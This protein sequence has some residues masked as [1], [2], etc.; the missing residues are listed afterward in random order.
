MSEYPQRQPIPAG[1]SS[2]TFL[3]ERKVVTVVFADISGFTA[4]SETLDPETVRDMMN[5]CFDMLVPVIERYGGTIDKFIGDAVMALFGA[6]TAHEND[7][8]RALRAA[9]G[10]IEAVVQ[11]NHE[12]GTDLGVHIGI[13]TG[14]VVAGGI[15]SQGRQ[16]YSV[17][18]DAVNLAARLEDASE[19][20]EILVGPDTARAVMQLFEFDA[21]R[22]I[23]FKG[24]SQPVP[25]YRL[26]GQRASPGRLRGI[27]GLETPIVGR[28]RE[29]VLLRQSLEGLER[30]RGH[31]IYLVGDA[32]LGKSRLID[33]LR[34][35]YNPG[36]C[37]VDVQAI[38]YQ[39]A[40]PYSLFQ[41]LLRRMANLDE[42]DAPELSRTRIA[43]MLEELTAQG[44]VAFPARARSAIEAL[45]GVAVDT[46]G[47]L[48]GESLRRELVEAITAV[49]QAWTA[50]GPA[51]IA[52]DDLHWADALSVELL[53]QL[54]ALVSNNPLLIICAFRPERQSPIQQLRLAT[55][56]YAA[57]YVHEIELRPLSPSESNSL[58]D[59]LLTIADLPQRLRELILEKA[60]GNPFFVEE[61]VRELILQE[62]VTRSAD[63]LRWYAV[64][65]IERIALPES[66]QA[67]LTTRIDRLDEAARQL[68]Q[69]AAVIGRSFG[70]ATLARVVDAD[71]A[72]DQA[73]GAL[74][75]ADLIYLVARQPE[76]EYAF[77]H[78]LAQEA[79]YASIL[80]RRRRAY[81]RRVGDAL[82]AL[83]PERL[84]ELAHQL[85]HHFAEA[86]DELRAL[87]YEL[88]AGDAAF[89][90]YARDAAEDHYRHALSIVR[91]NPAAAG[92]GVAATTRLSG[93]FT[94][95]GRALELG[96]RW[97]EAMALYVELI[98][99]GRER[100]DAQLELAGFLACAVVRATPN[101][102]QSASDA[103]ADGQAALELAR[104]LGNGSA[105]AR[106]L[107]SL[108]LA[109]SY[110][111]RPNEAL[112]YG[113]Q[114]LAIARQLNLREQMAY[115]LNDL[116][117]AYLVVRGPSAALVVSEEAHGLWRE[118]NNLPMLADNL[119]NLTL[120]AYLYGNYE[121]ALA[122][123]DEAVQ[124]SKVIGNTWG[125]ATNT[126]R[127]AYVY[128][129]WAEY[130]RAI[131][132]T[133]SS[134]GLGRQ[135]G[136]SFVEG[137]QVAELGLIYAL[138]GAHERA[139]ALA[140]HARS[141][142]EQVPPQLRAASLATQARLY[143]TIGD[144]AAARES[145]AACYALGDP[146]A[147]YNLAALMLPMVELDLALIEGRYDEVMARAAA[148]LKQSEAIGVRLGIA[149]LRHRRALAFQGL[150][151]LNSA[152]SE[153]EAARDH[154]RTIGSRQALWPILR[155]LA[156]LV[157][158]AD[159]VAALAYTAEA[160]SI[161]ATIAAAI[162]DLALRQSF[163]ARPAVRSLIAAE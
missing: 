29:L 131:A 127:T 144:H 50:R 93:L 126:N 130:S 71:L 91:H 73:L 134:I 64:A 115:S 85:A 72:V 49:W 23:Q 7:P 80:L 37:W 76:P 32:G 114:A 162:D 92:D 110:S 140:R 87:D 156:Q 34:T 52:L 128:L 51:V 86:G 147:T 55:S 158:P 141:Y 25:V 6:P 106:A 21:P 119:G 113:E 24:K 163:L 122:A 139:A 35:M 102:L 19:R 66:L 44:T 65:D 101:P 96:L 135:V 53:Q 38:S 48:E 160:S 117:L 154:A 40:R 97:E 83:Y 10:M 26:R 56:P 45:L 16:H 11:F 39:A 17:L 129:E 57:P 67:L 36:P 155:D 146:F 157:R 9:L 2:A 41:L 69:I 54:F 8:E 149:D 145:I 105:E 132:A 89:R 1:L 137:W 75:A 13:N 59:H 109:M 118:L 43:E 22:A 153:L 150:G 161:V 60:E 104:Q 63:G 12:H 70:A 98:G 20:G 124:I 47:R 33:E 121:R 94:R 112:V 14:L 61:V 138:L 151:E 79:A 81:H 84:D 142:A 103:Q 136:L 159:P 5:A 78:T 15:G 95:L 116:G 58:V 18:G 3:G 123:A 88:R 68:L 90:L 4:L 107:W 148:L 30:G 42:L 62:I 74:Q 82:E 133:E 152:R 100:G 31:V 28:E 77:R 143:F 46:P 99:M 125:E 108:Q 120:I 111:N 27:E